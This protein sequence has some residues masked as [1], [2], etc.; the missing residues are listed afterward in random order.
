MPVTLD[1]LRS[2]SPGTSGETPSLPSA[3]RFPEVPYDAE[4]HRI[5][6]LPQRPQPDACSEEAH[7]LAAFITER[8]GKSTELYPGPLRPLQGLAVREGVMNK[9]GL[10][11]IGVG[12]GKSLVDFLLIEA[13]Q[14]TRPLIITKGAMVK[15][16]EKERK[17][18]LK[19]WHIRPAHQCPILSF[20]LLS[21]P[22]SG[23]ELDDDGRVRVKSRLERLQPT[24]IIIDEVQCF[25]DAGATG[26]KRM[27]AFMEKFP[28]TICWAQT[29]T[30]FRN[31]IEEVEHIARWCLKDRAFFPNNGQYFKTLKTWAS[32]M[33]ARSGGM[34]GVRAGV[35]AL[36]EFLTPEE[37]EKFQQLEWE[38]DRT[39]MIR[40][41]FSRHMFGIPGVI[42]TTNPPLD[43]PLIITSWIPEADCPA[44][45][46]LFKYLNGD[47][48]NSTEFPGYRLP[49]GTE[50]ADGM[51]KARHTNT[52]GFNH[53]NFWRPD[54]GPDWRFHRNTWSKWCRRKI[55]TNRKGIDS[56][57]RMKD[58]VRRGVP[59]FDD[60]WTE[61]ECRLMA[62]LECTPEQWA[63]WAPLVGTS[64][65]ENWE[66][67]DAEW[68]AE[69][70]L[71]EPPSVAAFVS[72]QIV[73]EVAKWLEL[74]EG[75]VWVNSIALGNLLAERLSIPYYGAGGVTK[76]GVDIKSHPGGSA[77]ASVKANGTGKNLQG[78]WC[79]A[80][81]LCTPEEQ[82]LAR[83]HRPGQKADAVRNWV[84]L[85]CPEH[86]KKFHAARSTKAAFAEQLQNSPQKL[87]Y[88]QVDMPKESEL[89]DLGGFRWTNRDDAD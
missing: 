42:G 9:G 12:E 7:E 40:R 78:F 35:G 86:L 27:N 5:Y 64:R 77:I 83:L 46:E 32:V 58:V 44:T 54:P 75:L 79:N 8:M 23:E 21:Q 61:D 16:L 6:S 60:R 68:K 80:L 1:Q 3:M 25:G 4:F 24:H 72:E 34:G 18:F 49:D 69:T 50:C 76:K 55:K 81:W 30:L 31:S 43:I 53:W 82:A 14:A 28:E 62:G 66:G 29:G 65:L 59:G 36:I 10:G 2:A 85:G 19:S 47:P 88:A 63:Q 38:Q 57:A 73:E 26:T 13:W 74:Y 84:Y 37:R 48:N 39:E 52:G 33:D 87:R 17:K 11:I 56:E 51:Q 89:E 41:A 70:G 45:D 20:E 22:S 67:I 71:L 15:D